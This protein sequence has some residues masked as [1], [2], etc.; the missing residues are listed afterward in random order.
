MEVDN[1]IIGAG[2]S[3]LA[4]AGR[5]SKANIPYTIIEQSS[6]IADRWHRHYDRLHLH[7]VKSL[8]QLP[9]KDF[10]SEY[11]TYVSR[12]DLV[13][14]YESYAEEMS[15]QPQFNT[16]AQEIH[17][18]DDSFTTRLNN[19]TNIKS[20]NVILASGINRIPN[21][22]SFENR[23]AYQGKVIHSIDYKN[24]SPYIG[25]SVLVI[26]MGNTGAE[27]ALDLAEQGARP[28]ICVRGEISLVPRDINGRPVQTTSKILQK[29]PFGLGD[30]IG[31]QVQKVVFG[32]LS[33]YGLRISKEYPVQVLMK[34]GKTPV[35]DIGTV[36]KIKSGEIKVRPG[37]DRFTAEGVLF[38]D[39]KSEQYDAII[40]AT[41]YKAKVKE[42]IPNI[43]S[44]DLDQYHLPKHTIWEG[45]WKGLYTIGFDNYS[46]GGILGTVHNQSGLIVQDIV[47][48][49]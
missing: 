17:K 27:I 44:H 14:Y 12:K 36:A 13:S 26:G 49:G 15:I 19:G 46:L 31:A 37:I 1:L 45:D 35:I 6:N 7:T 24:P 41:G 4:V 9:H 18:D 23:E 30:W 22:P 43:P 32:D 21:I 2:P 39:G 38:E 8:S 42:L 47:Q 28:S 34:T 25:Q 16:A 11:P 48:Q 10:P 3:G 20:K 40:L 33:K 29:F 5:F